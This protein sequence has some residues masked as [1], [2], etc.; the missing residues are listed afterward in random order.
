[1]TIRVY[2]EGKFEN[3]TES[4]IFMVMVLNMTK[5]L[6]MLKLFFEGSPPD[7]GLLRNLTYWTFKSH[8]IASNVRLQKS[9]IP[10]DSSTKTAQF[11]SI[12][13]PFLF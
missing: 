7:S 4:F 8:W 11:E 13:E 12:W 3:D 6:L 5:Y 10:L 1:M 9:Q 2:V